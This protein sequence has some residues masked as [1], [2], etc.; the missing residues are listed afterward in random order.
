MVVLPFP[1]IFVSPVFFFFL[2]VS[3][4]GRKIDQQELILMSCGG[5]I[6]IRQKMQRVMIRIRDGDGGPPQNLKLNYRLMI[7]WVISG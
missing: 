3:P 4:I 6:E 7:C 5:A 2:V 1:R